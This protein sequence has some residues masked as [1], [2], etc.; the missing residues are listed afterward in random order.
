M[1]RIA[2]NVVRDRIVSIVDPEARHGH[3]GLA[4]GCGVGEAELAVA[5]VRAGGLLLVAA[6]WRWMSRNLVVV[7]KSGR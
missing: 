5:A 6:C 3:V 4:F 1:F 7:W 2:R